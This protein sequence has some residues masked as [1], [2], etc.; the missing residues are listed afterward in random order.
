MLPRRLLLV[1]SLICLSLVGVAFS[2]PSAD[3]QRS[4][5]GKETDENADM[6]CVANLDEGTEKCFS[7]FSDAIFEGTKGRVRVPSNLREGKITEE[8]LNRGREKKANRADGSRIGTAAQSGTVIGIEYEN[9]RYN[10]YTRGAT[11][12]FTVNN[13]D[14]CRNGD[15]W[16]VYSVGAVWGSFWQDRISSARSFQGCR[17]PHY[18]HS[19]Y[20]R[21]SRGGVIYT[22]C[23]TMGDMNDLTSSIQWFK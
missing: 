3:A 21:Y 20:N 1:A 18:E 10:N 8:I 13:V 22:P 16:G 5:G 15:N 11:Y 7:T 9:T 2:V 4:S 17:A 6:H 19:N 12:T 23:Y 14:G